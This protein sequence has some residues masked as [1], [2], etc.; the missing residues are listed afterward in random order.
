MASKIIK[1]QSF[2]GNMILCL[3]FLIFVALSPRERYIFISAHCQQSTVGRYSVC[4]D[5]KYDCVCV[6]LHSTL[7]L[8]GQT[9][10]LM[11]KKY[12]IIYKEI[13]NR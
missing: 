12:L 11:E 2:S 6:C 9:H 13:C 4:T 3:Y 5:S 8:E 1:T 7:S 10:T